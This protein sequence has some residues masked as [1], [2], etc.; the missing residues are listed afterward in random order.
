M[1]FG[2][3]MRP[4]SG[5]EFFRQL[6]TTVL[7]VQSNAQLGLTKRS[8]ITRTPRQRRLPPNALTRIRHGKLRS[9]PNNRRLSALPRRHRV[10][11][12]DNALSPAA[13]RAN[14]RTIEQTQKPNPPTT[15]PR[16]KETKLDARTQPPMRN[17][18][19]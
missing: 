16:H 2:L 17:R 10:T 8:L 11:P 1:R 15:T 3:L 19:L 7:G 6:P 5:L 9:Q 14:R 12:I 13:F 4:G 18:K